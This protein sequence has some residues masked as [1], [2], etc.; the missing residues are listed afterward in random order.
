MAIA[1]RV[2][3]IHKAYGEQVILDGATGEIRDDHRLAVIGRNGAGKSTLCRIILGQEEADAGSIAI[4]RDTRVAYLEQHDTFQDGETV[5]GYLARAS[6]QEEWRC[7]ELAGKFLLSHELL[8]RPVRSMSGGFQTRAKLCAMLLQDPTFLVL[9]EPTNYLDTATQL[10]LERFITSFRGGFLVVSHDREFL[11]RTCTSTLEVAQGRMR[12]H[13]GA[14]DHWLSRKAEERVDAERFNANQDLKRK[15]LEDFV[16]RNRARASTAARAQ[17]KQKQLDRLETV[18]VSYDDVAP[19]I[20]LPRIEDRPGAALRVD[21]LA[22][23]YGP[24]GDKPGRTIASK[25]DIEIDRGKKVAIIGENGQGKTTLLRTLA[26]DLPALGGLIKWGY[27]IRLGV[28][29]QHVYTTMD[30][31]KTV[32]ETIFAAAK[33]APRQWKDQELLDLAGTFLFRGESVDKKVSVLSGG[34][35]SRLCLCCL[36]VGGYEALLLDEPTNHL[37]VETVE[38]LGTALKQHNGTAL[39]VSHDRSF[40][41]AV[42]DIIIE[43]KDGKVLVVPDGYEAWLWRLEQQAAEADPG[44]GARKKPAKSA[45]KSPDRGRNE[46]KELERRIAELEREQRQ[47]VDR[48]ATRHD[49]DTARRLAAVQRELATAEERYFALGAG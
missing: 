10:L 39:L 32:R 30:A 44:G 24:Q 16:A 18:E 45:E 5:L 3:D 12:I 37:D 34:E 1:I 31:A 26:A 36:L 8:D 49:A 28:Y 22:I 38:A 43:V 48:L 29:A 21:G 33:L 14:V 40:V 7:A 35:R 9:D 25:I 2:T 20:R 27:A 19:V 13:E 17:A 46:I 4:G 15:A 6:G 41:Q 47:L 42:A 11:R 23:G